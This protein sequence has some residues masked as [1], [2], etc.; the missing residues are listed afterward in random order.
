VSAALTAPALSAVPDVG[1]FAA[2]I[3]AAGVTA[4]VA[5][6]LMLVGMHRTARLTAL[7]ALGTVGLG[8]GVVAIA[9][10]GVVAISPS[11]AHAETPSNGPT[12]VVSSHDDIQL[13]TLATD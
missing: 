8:V 10:G 6:G 9:V 3:V 5:L 13:P 1:I 12:Y 7:H 11:S 2:V 4:L